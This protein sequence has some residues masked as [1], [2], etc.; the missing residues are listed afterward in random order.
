MEVL[1]PHS[2]SN[3]TTLYIH[4][5]TNT[6][7][8]WNLVYLEMFFTVYITC[9][10]SHITSHL[11]H[12]LYS[13]KPHSTSN[14]TTLYIHSKNEQIPE[15]KFGVPGNVFIWKVCVTLILSHITSHS[16]HTLYPIKPHSIF[17]Q[18]RSDTMAET[19]C[20]WKMQ[21]FGTVWVTCI[22]SHS[23][24]TLHPIKPHSL[25]SYNKRTNTS[26]ETRCT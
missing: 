11:T 16:N 15:Q 21:F 2:T 23:T 17:I 13:F 18:N 5:K 20:T 3:Q 24:H 10:L 7:Q 12:T 9:I 22:L 1:K 19:R 4:S 25:Y 6:N 26:A 14:Q 8:G